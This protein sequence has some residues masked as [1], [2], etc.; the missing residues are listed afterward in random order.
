V[1]ESGLAVFERWRSRPPIFCCLNQGM[2]NWDMSGRF[3]EISGPCNKTNLV[4]KIATSAISSGQKNEVLVLDCDS[5]FKM[6]RIVK[7]I[8]P[9]D[10]VRLRLFRI[11]DWDEY[12]MALAVLPELLFQTPQLNMIV[13]DGLSNPYLIQDQKK[14][15]GGVTQQIFRILSILEPYN[16][17]C[18]ITVPKPCGG[19]VEFSKIKPIRISTSSDNT[20]C[21][22]QDPSNI[23]A[24]EMDLA[25]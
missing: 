2:P 25:S 9:K 3:V 16:I 19:D 12:Q 6:D 24:F 5:G 15:H 8:D 11:F 1:Q 7:S 20:K 10:F 14:Q 18:V 21:F 17:T 4:L 13:I 22:V 23:V